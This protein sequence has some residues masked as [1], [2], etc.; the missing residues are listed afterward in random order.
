MRSL[1]TTHDYARIVRAVRINA[2]HLT[3]AR[4]RDGQSKS[5][6]AKRVGISLQYLCDIE[7]GKRT[8][9]RNP[10]LIKAM[11][12]ALGVPVSMLAMPSTGE[13]VA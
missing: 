3:I 7:A 2:E 12:E 4:E 5:E 6:F 11:A 10:G 1:L 8:L 9:C 13:E